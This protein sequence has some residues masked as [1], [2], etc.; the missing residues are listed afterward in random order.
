MQSKRSIKILGNLRSDYQGYNQIVRFISAMNPLRNSEIIIDFKLVSFLEANLSAILGVAFEILES[1]G[2]KISLINLQPQVEKILSKNGLL[3]SYG[4]DPIQDYHQTTLPYKKFIPGNDQGFN[5]YIMKYLLKQPSFPSHSNELGKQIL[6]NIFEIFENARTHGDCEYI[7]TCGQFFPR[8][9]V[10]PLHFTIV[11]KGINIQEN[12]NKFLDEE[13]NAGEAIKW[14]MKKGNTTKTGDT[15]GG[16]GLSVI[17]EFIK[18][19][20]GKIHI[21]SADGFYEFSDGKE[22]VSKLNSRF[23]GTIVNIR[24]NLNDTSYYSLKSETENNDIIF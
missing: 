9:D 21:I 14:A 18:L 12:V 8:K 4:Y 3:T 24:F 1:N 19:N 23:N 11:D 10:K 17:F 2:N 5:N 13:L 22:T 20:K 7:H 6:R 15:S 16:L